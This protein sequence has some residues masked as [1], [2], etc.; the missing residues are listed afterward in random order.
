[1][2]W[3]LLPAFV[4]VTLVGAIETVG[5]AVAIQRIAWRRPRAV[6][7]RAVQ[8]AV[9]ADG[10]GNLLSGLAGTVPNTTYSTSVSVAELTGVGARR[11]GVAVGILFL[12]MA[13][14]P[15]VLAVILA[16][17]GPVASAYLTVLLSMLFVVGMRVVFQDGIDY[18]K[19]LVCGVSF[20]IGVGFQNGVI[21]P[22]YFA[23]FAG[24]LLQNG[25]TA[26]GL[27]AI[28]MTLFVELTGARRSR[29]QVEFDV[30]ALPKISEFLRAFASR[31]GWD[32]AMADRLDAVGEE[33]LL[34]LLQDKSEAERGQRRLLLIAYEEDGGAHLEFIAGTGDENIQDRIALLGARTAGELIEIEQ[35]VSL[36]LLRHLS[37]SVR[38]Q[39]YYDTDIVTVR[40]DRPSA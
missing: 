26:G 8:G 30:S 23:E 7:F 20:W 18:R 39:Q 35:E 40:V 4:F 13:F 33:G 12:A 14:F 2:F 27:V 25:M 28:L 1:M 37:S 38:H 3:G 9:A 17:P 24:G 19:G 11:V 5:D 34:T 6:D 10:V 16:I 31:M 29:V 15:K 21:F 22:E 32:A 36:R